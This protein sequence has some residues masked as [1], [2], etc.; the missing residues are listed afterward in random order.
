MQRKT[1]ESKSA[2][3]TAG[4]RFRQWVV[5]AYGIFWAGLAISP[6]NRADWALENLLVLFFFVGLSVS[7]HW[8]TLSLLSFLSIVAFLSLHAVGAH[9]TYSLVPYDHWTEAL[10]GVSVSDWF[11]AA[12]NHYDRVVHFAYGLLLTGPIREVLGV[13]AGLRAIGYFFVPAM[14]ILGFSAAYEVVEW[15]AAELFGAELGIAYV[16]AQGDLWDAQKDM[17][18]AGAGA[19]LVSAIGFAMRNRGPIPER[20]NPGKVREN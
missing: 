13:G 1:E 10:A 16:G 8:R 19:L 7:G 12:R 15:C 17:A 9:Y 4:P 2:G 3:W 20:R 6:V 5:L 11:G 14:M 18:L